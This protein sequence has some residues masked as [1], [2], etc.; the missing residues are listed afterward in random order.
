MSFARG[1][2]FDWLSDS[3]LVRDYVVSYSSPTA[4]M[5]LP[6]L[7]QPRICPREIYDLML[8]CWNVDGSQRPTFHEIHMFLTRKGI[9]FRHAG[10]ENVNEIGS[11]GFPSEIEWTGND[12]K[13]VAVVDLMG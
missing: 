7:P 5:P 12:N 11:M 10:G 9:G 13:A 8:E 6:R 3:Q 2:P 4:A 1:R